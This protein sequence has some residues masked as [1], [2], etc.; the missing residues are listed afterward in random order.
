LRDLAGRGDLQDED[1]IALAVNLLRE[2]TA[3]ATLAG[4][5]RLT[6][7]LADELWAFSQE[8]ESAFS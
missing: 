6:Q 4:D 7:M 3:E 8:A 2:K 1:A 5:K